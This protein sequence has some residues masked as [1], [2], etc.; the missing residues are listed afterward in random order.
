MKVDPTTKEYEVMREILR[1]TD[2]YQR[3]INEAVNSEHA[4]NLRNQLEEEVYS[5]L[6]QRE[7]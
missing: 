3:L 1:K 4:R 7:W 6:K 2:H 5:I